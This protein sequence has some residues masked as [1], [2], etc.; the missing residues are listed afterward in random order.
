MEQKP[1]GQDRIEEK[2]R[3]RQKRHIADDGHAAMPA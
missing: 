1:S 2:G 3:Y